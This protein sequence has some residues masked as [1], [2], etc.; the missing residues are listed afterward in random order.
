V[1]GVE[2]SGEENEGVGH[3]VIRWNRLFK[4]LAITV[5]VLVV[6]LLVVKLIRR[7]F[8]PKAEPVISR[9]NFKPGRKISLGRINWADNQHNLILYLDK[10]C[11]H[12]KASAP[13]YRRLAQ[14][15]AGL[16]GVR[17]LAV[18]SRATDD[19]QGYL[20]EIGLSSLEVVKAGQEQFWI[21][22]TPTLVLVNSEGVISGLWIGELNNERES[23]V[24]QRL[25]ETDETRMKRGDGWFRWQN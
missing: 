25:R 17:L 7:T 23:A 21:M 19:G 14:E 4:R 12:C 8:F 6:S 2:A 20:N 22:P 15:A 9:A 5:L 1:L 3:M 13:F 11:E 10:S 24:L 16:K 18:L